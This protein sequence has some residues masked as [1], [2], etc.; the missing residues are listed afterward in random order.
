MILL[1]WWHS[2]YIVLDANSSIAKLDPILIMLLENYFKSKN[3]KHN[4]FYNI[5][6]YKY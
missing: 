5:F 2:N 1:P 3:I 6:I 4:D